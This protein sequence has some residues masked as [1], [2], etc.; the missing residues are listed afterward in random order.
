MSKSDQWINIILVV[1]ILVYLSILTVALVYHKISWLTQLNIVSALSVIFYWIQKQFRISQH[2][3]DPL[4][5]A[6]LCFEVA[7]IGVAVYSILNKQS[8]NWLIIIQKIVFGIH[9]SAMI[10]FL[11][12]MLTF[13]I[14]RLI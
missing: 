1:I 3:I 5:I 12:F 8:V 9:L 6:V 7:V 11:V 10:L 13:K 2:T 4:E 14:N